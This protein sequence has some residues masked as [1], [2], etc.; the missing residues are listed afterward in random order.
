[1]YEND[2]IMRMIKSGLQ[3]IASIFIK[4]NSIEDSIENNNVFIAEDQLLEIMLKKY[5][6]DGEINKAEDMIFEAVEAHK[7]PR[8]LELSLFFYKEIS[9]WSEDKLRSCN[10]S[11]EE[12]LEGIEAIE[13]LFN[14]VEPC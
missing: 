1:M 8:N 3:A 4:N 9:S 2:Y 6:S 13:K 11:R 14:E 10:F 5:L 7:S 12:I